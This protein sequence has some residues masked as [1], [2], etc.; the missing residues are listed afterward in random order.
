MVPKYTFMPILWPNKEVSMK[1]KGLMLTCLTLLNITLFSPLFADSNPNPYSCVID[2]EFGNT[3]LVYAP[4]AAWAAAGSNA[5][6]DSV[7]TINATAIPDSIKEYGTDNL[8]PPAQHVGEYDNSLTFN[9]L[10][11][12]LSRQSWIQNVHAQI[13]I[14][15][16]TYDFKD[17]LVMYSNISLKGEGSDATTLRFLIVTDSTMSAA[18]CKKDA[19]L[20]AGPDYAIITKV[21]IEN[22]KIIRVQGDDLS[23]NQISEM[24]MTTVVTGATTLQSAEQQTAG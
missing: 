9:M 17:Q 5:V 4:L 21:G 16:G 18:D 12:S 19:I 22:L 13:Y 1:H 14:P 24:L 8:I 11:Y 15:P 7:I 20:V 3:D 2:P 23:E 10:M 6:I